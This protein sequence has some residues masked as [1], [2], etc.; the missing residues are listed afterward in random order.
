[1]PTQKKA[2]PSSLSR[3]CTDRARE[4]Y[5]RLQ[6]KGETHV[7]EM[8]MVSFSYSFSLA[9]SLLLQHRPCT[10]DVVGSFKRLLNGVLEEAAMLEYIGACSNIRSILASGRMAEQI[11]FTRYHRWERVI[12]KTLTSVFDMRLCVHPSPL[13]NT[14]MTFLGWMKRVPVCIRD[15][16]ESIDD[17]FKN[18]RRLSSISFDDKYTPQLASILTEW[19]CSYKPSREFRFQHGSGSTAD[20]GKVRSHKWR[21][22]RHDLR[23]RILMKSAS[24]ESLI[25]DDSRLD[26]CDRISK[27]VFVPKQAGKDR[28]ICMEPSWLQYLQQG[29][30]RDLMRYIERHPLLS[31]YIQ[32]SNQDNN[33]SLCAQAYTRKLCTIDLSDASDSVSWR[34]LKRTIRGTRLYRYLYACRSDWTSVDG[35]LVRFDKFAPMGS[36]LC[37]PI[38]CVIF[39][40][41]VELAHRI[42]YGC[43]SS[44]RLSGC[45]VYGDDI[46]CP[47]EIY[48]LVVDILETVG[49]KVNTDKSFGSGPYYESCGVEYLYGALIKTIK[50]PRSHLVPNKVVSP[51]SVGLITDLA[52]TLLD[53]GYFLARRELLTSYKESSIRVGNRVYPFFDVFQF[54]PTTCRTL[55]DDYSKGTFD[56]GYQR[57]FKRKTSIE[58][59]PKPS[60]QD[61][62]EFS[63][64]PEENDEGT[65]LCCHERWSLKGAIALSKLGHQDLLVKGDIEPVCTTRTGPLRLRA[66][67]KKIP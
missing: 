25:E 50:H 53:S 42:H 16:R 64:R 60:L 19:L 54:G 37:F 28:T 23:A 44:G 17:V 6:S 32:F 55:L 3:Y 4:V 24:L 21:N 11:S 33:R 48:H 27:L 40:S 47:A 7:S 59:Q 43:A 18:D 52:N 57:S 9:C 26:I 41:I 10:P 63:H 34:L 13:F 29:V 30:A 58:W 61:W 1:M 2:Q 62:C 38:E 51:E 31:Q 15:T 65:S 45:S 22:H 5:A 35:Y 12:W 20:V 56:D 46:I 39:A 36:A 49:F 8:D 14:V 66:L 67:L